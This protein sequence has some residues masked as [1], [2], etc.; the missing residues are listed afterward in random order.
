[1]NWRKQVQLKNTSSGRILHGHFLHLMYV[2][3]CETLSLFQNRPFCSV[4]STG[5]TAE[6][7]LMTKV[8]NDRYWRTLVSLTDQR[9]LGCSRLTCQSPKISIFH[10]FFWYISCHTYTPT[11]RTARPILRGG[12]SSVWKNHNALGPLPH[13]LSPESQIKQQQN[14]VGIWYMMKT[15]GRTYWEL[16]VCQWLDRLWPRYCMTYVRVY[17]LDIYQCLT[18]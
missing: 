2:T 1:M 5:P 4:T 7:I 3:K 8:V 6:L 10:V 15:W 9:A 14:Y 17:I 16:Y 12:A 18:T 13:G 11:G